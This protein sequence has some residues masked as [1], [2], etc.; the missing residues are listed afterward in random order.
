[1]CTTLSVA[2]PLSDSLDSDVFLLNCHVLNEGRDLPV[3]LI[4]MDVLN[5]GIILGMD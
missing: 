2:T 3:D 1:M 4:P 5:F